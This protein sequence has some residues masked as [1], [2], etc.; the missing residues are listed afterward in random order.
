MGHFLFRHGRPARLDRDLPDIAWLEARRE[1][2][3]DG[4]FITHAHEDHVGA[5]GAISVGAVEGAGALRAASPRCPGR[6]A[7][8]GR[9]RATTSK[10]VRVA[11]SGPGRSPPG[12][13]TGSRPE[14]AIRS[15]K[16]RRW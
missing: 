14:S 6:H 9:K 5:V 11:P 12:P 7:Q 4:I 1:P 13:F 15:P 2:L 16:P 8:A 3:I 10:Q